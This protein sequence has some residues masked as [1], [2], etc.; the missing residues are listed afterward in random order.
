MQKQ[1][2]VQLSVF[3]PVDMAD[4]IEKLAA[5]ARNTKSDIVRELLQAALVIP[6]TDRHIELIR[7]AIEEHVKTYHMGQAL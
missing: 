3:V 2:M 7:I 6:P 5:A 4:K 1:N